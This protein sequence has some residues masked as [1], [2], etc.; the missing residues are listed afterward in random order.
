M[1][2]KTAE[3]TQ[4]A[5]RVAVLAVLAVLLAFYGMTQLIAYLGWK[6]SIWH[7]IGLWLLGVAGVYLYCE[8]QKRKGPE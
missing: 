6:P 2:K 5:I 8:Y 4:W 3:A 1:R 7:P